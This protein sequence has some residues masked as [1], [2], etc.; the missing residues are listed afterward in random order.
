MTCIH[1]RRLLTVL[2]LVHFP[3]P[4]L[5][6]PT[7]DGCT[8]AEVTVALS[9]ALVSREVYLIFTLPSLTTAVKYQRKARRH[10]SRPDVV[11]G[12]LPWA[13]GRPGVSSGVPAVIYG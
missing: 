7:A 2:H 9:V 13:A 12:A 11:R 3:R 5:A 4:R 1:G 8:D 6:V 10:S